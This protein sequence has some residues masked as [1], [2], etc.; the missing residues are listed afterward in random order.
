MKWHGERPLQR[1]NEEA[2]GLLS[3]LTGILRSR[4]TGEKGTGGK[5]SLEEKKLKEKKELVWGEKM[6]YE[7]ELCDERY[8][9]KPQFLFCLTQQMT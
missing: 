4:G 5:G 2:S 7:W 1:K 6:I 8:K 9:Y 3:N